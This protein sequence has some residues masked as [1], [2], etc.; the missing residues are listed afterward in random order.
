MA[1]S[2]AFW[3][4]RSK[5]YEDNV[6]KPNP[7]REQRVART[8]ALLG[9]SHVVLDFGCA[10]GEMSLAIAPDVYQIQGIDLSREM[11]MAARRKTAERGIDNVR[12]DQMAAFDHRLDHNSFTAVI[13]FNVF[14]LVEDPKK[15][16]A[17]LND[18][19]AARGLLIAQVP[20]LGDWGWVMRSM[21]GLAQKIGWAPTI[22]NF[23]VPEMEA[24]VTD[25]NFAITESKNYDAR[26]VVQWIVAHK[27]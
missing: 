25:A 21:L 6:G 24:L 26:Q 15:V 2:E 7:A 3:D 5:A 27:T 10:T 11:I 23:T 12:F 1:Q 9:E 13:A 20:C 8:K 17:W 19:L 22:H 14:H 4:K 18:L 16:L